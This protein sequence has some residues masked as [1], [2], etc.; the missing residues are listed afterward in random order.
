[1]KT[2]N[3]T[4]FLVA[5]LLVAGLAC[6]AVTGGPTPD[7]LE[8]TARVA[9]AVPATAEQLSAAPADE[10]PVAPTPTN[11]VEAGS[12]GAGAV[13]DLAALTLSFETVAQ[14]LESP[15]GIANAG[16]GS[17]RL[18]IIE[19]PGRI[20]VVQ[21]GML[22]DTAF[23]DITDR[24]DSDSYERGLLGLA[25]HPGYASN[26]WFF[27]NYTD[28][29]GNT[30]VA[31]Y[32]VTADPN[33]ADPASERPLLN[34]NQPASNHNGGHVVF[35]PDGYLY[36]GFGDGGAAGDVFANGQNTNS[37]LGSILR[38]DVD[39]IPYRIPADNPYAGTDAVLDEI[40]AYG[41][42]NPWRFSFDSLTGDMY[43]AD[44]GQNIYEE[45]NVQPASSPGGENYGW[46]IMEGF[47][48]YDSDTCDETGLTM[49]VAEYN[50]SQGCSVTGGYV[51]RGEDYPALYGVYL[52][53]DFCTGV[54]WGLAPDETGG[55]NLRELTTVGM[56]ISTFGEGEDGTLYIADMAGGTVSTI[57][58][59]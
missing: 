9:T 48:C 49:P 55:W 29:S 8:P 30:V 12:P 10:N 50:H 13:P 21:D 38:I 28:R 6:R 46:P 36:I 24:V 57:I 17:N 18:F 16:D 44:V 35:G 42:R 20:R 59:Q 27:V 23:L 11:E 32:E 47:S 7:N 45:I 58:A 3:Y 14:G 37:L 25:F 15:I 54:M 22:L 5:A 56:Q 2:G 34:V 51:Y 4:L 41:V 53:G 39:E 40:W 52:F 43:M 19:K 31:R 26:G 1:M 33:I